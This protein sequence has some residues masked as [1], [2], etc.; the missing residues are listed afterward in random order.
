MKFR[1]TA[2]AVFEAENI[3]DAFRRLS[4]HF[5]QLA[6]HG[7]DGLDDLSEGEQLFE[8]GS[9]EIIKYRD[10]GEDESR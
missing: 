2:N 6:D 5:L 1:L 8:D 3:D 10:Y 4:V 9:C 7:L